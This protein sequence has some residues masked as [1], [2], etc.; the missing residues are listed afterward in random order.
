MVRA[1]YVIAHQQFLLAVVTGTAVVAYVVIV[2]CQGMMY[3]QP[4]IVSI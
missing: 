4:V 3:A 2:S 1:L